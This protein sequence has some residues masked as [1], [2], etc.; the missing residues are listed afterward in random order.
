MKAGYAWARTD[1]RAGVI[2]FTEA[3]AYSAEKLRQV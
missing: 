1:C 2:I 3:A